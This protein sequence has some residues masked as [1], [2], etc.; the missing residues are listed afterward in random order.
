M[1]KSYPRLRRL[2]LKSL[3]AT[4][5]MLES[6]SFFELVNVLHHAPVGAVGHPA[7]FDMAMKGFLVTFSFTYP[8]ELAEYNTAD[9]F[10]AQTGR[11]Q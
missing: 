2:H 10:H 4:P 7:R 3:A 8:E 11:M 1:R 9:L 5:A 6:E